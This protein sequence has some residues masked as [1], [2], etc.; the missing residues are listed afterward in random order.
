[1]IDLP[2]SENEFWG[3]EAEKIAIEIKSVKP[4]A[5]HY[6]VW[7]GPFAVCTSCAFEHTVPLD[8][9]KYDLK[10]GIPCKRD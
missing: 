6:L 10:D 8:R 9:K 2:K 1:M 4:R 3:D 5:E 7:R